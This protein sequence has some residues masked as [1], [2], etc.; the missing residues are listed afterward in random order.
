MRGHFTTTTCSLILCL[1][2]MTASAAPPK[3]ITVQG[4]LTDASGNPLAAGAKSFVFRIFNAS[5]LGTQIW[6]TV[7]G[8]AQNISSN[9]AG[10]WTG[11]LGAVNPLTD[12]VFAD[13]VRWL[14]V[15]VNGQVLPR[16]R[17]E[18]GPYAMRVATVDG[19]TGG[20]VSGMVTTTGI[21]EGLR[22]EGPGQ[23]AANEAYMRFIDNVGGSTGYIGDAHPGNRDMYLLSNTG[24]LQLWAGSGPVLTA[25]SGGTVGIGPSA[26]TFTVYDGGY[27]HFKYELQIGGLGPELTG[28]SEMFLVRNDNWGTVFRVEDDNEATLF[29]VDSDGDAFLSGNLTQGFVS[30]KIDHPLDPANKYLSHSVVESPDL[31]NIYN[32]IVTTDATGSATVTMPMWFEALNRDFRYQL[33]VIGQFAQAIISEEMTGGKFSIKTDKSNVKV[34]WQVTGIRQDAYANAHRIK[35]EE[36]KPAAERGTYLHP[37]LFTQPE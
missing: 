23:G 13:S 14:E 4:V 6:P 31:M 33:T 24:G 21:A 2:A 19:A 32:G 28:R 15:T 7:G 34:S 16:V 8:E 10:L 35:V 11:A 18:S 30:T 12:V 20:R 22:I 1:I 3:L 17:L 26:N 29:R 37:D 27:A 9:A 5:S 36:E 25:D